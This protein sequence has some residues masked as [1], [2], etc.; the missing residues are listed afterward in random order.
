MRKICLLLA[1]FFMASAVWAQ[2]AIFTEVSGKVEYQTAGG[3]WKPALVNDKIGKGALIST[4]FKSTAVVM[5]GPTSITLKPITRLTLEQ[6]IQTEGGTQTELYLLSGRVKADVPPQVGKTTEFKVKSPTA[7]ASVRGT[8]FEFDGVNLIVD[9][10][11]V[12]LFTPTGQFRRVGASEFSYVSA[13][14]VVASPSAVVLETGLDRVDELVEQSNSE[15][16]ANT[17]SVPALSVPITAITI[18][19]Q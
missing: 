16:L 8:G 2:Q 19:L 6:M 3:G 4:G 12:Q 15:S 9:R 5:V 11:T 18:R 1:A 7:T 13:G 14:G 10:G 17:T